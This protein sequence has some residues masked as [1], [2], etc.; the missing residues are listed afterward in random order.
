MLN[1]RRAQHIRKADRAANAA[2]YP[3]LTFPEIYILDGGYKFFFDMHRTRCFPQKYREMDSKGYEMACEQGLNKLR[4]PSKFI[5]S[6][7]FAY[8]SQ[9]CQLEDSP[10]ASMT[11]R[12]DTAMNDVFDCSIFDPRRTL[13]RRMPSY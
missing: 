5:R 1:G 6:K 4:R 2:M 12:G 9:S 11:S 13:S 3:K 10:T 8:G 7:T